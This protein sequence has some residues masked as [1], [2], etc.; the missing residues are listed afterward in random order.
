MVFSYSWI[1]MEII[2]LCEI[3]Q[4]EKDT[5]YSHSSIEFNKN[6]TYN[7]NYYYLLFN[8]NKDET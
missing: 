5:E 4:K 2:K 7:N 3:S 8:D 6:K 1:D